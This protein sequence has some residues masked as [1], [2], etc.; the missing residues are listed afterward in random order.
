MDAEVTVNVMVCAFTCNLCELKCISNG[1]FVYYM[2]FSCAPLPGCILIVV[3]KYLKYL[4]CFLC[5]KTVS[6][7][8]DIIEVFKNLREISAQQVIS[9]AGHRTRLT[10]LCMKKVCKSTPCV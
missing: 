10:F 5:E 9:Q 6:M 3:L 7:L 8:R 4:S 1:M 2:Y